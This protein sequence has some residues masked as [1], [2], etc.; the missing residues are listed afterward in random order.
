MNHFSDD[1]CFLLTIQLSLLSVLWFVFVRMLQR[2]SSDPKD[3]FWSVSARLFLDRGNFR[4]AESISGKR[5]IR[6]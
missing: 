4:K 1:I 3:S 2:F 6:P 5:S